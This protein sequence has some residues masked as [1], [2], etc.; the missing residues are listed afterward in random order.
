LDE[1]ID[2][3]SE[4]CVLDAEGK[5]RV[6]KLLLK[7][8]EAFS[9]YDELGHCRDIQVDI[10]LKD[11]TPFYIK[12]SYSRSSQRSYGQRVGEVGTVGDFEERLFAL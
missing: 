6:R 7:H 2:L 3:D 8:K 4:T 9:L 11:H 10:D 12:P 1:S 5:H